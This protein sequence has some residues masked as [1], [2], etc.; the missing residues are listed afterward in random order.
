MCIRRIHEG[1]LNACSTASRLARREAHFMC[2]CCSAEPRLAAPT[3][4]QPP[5]PTCCPSC[6]LPQGHA[7]MTRRYGGTGL[8]LAISRR[9]AHLMGGDV[10]VESEVRSW[11]WLP[12]TGWMLA[13]LGPWGRKLLQQRLLVRDAPLL[14]SACMPCGENGNAVGNRTN[15]GSGRVEWIFACIARLL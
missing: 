1:V 15:C 11:C 6:L 9:L 5:T 2:C 7:S 10:W 14:S 3:I 12:Q 8:G 13:A 4:C